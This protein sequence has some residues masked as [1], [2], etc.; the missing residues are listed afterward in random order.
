M[1][2][3]TSRKICGSATYI[4]LAKIPAFLRLTPKQADK[5]I[6]TKVG[7]IRDYFRRCGFKKAV[8]GLSGGIDSAVAA[9]LTA[10]AIGPENVIVLRLPCGPESVSVGIAGEICECLG[11]TA[12]NV[13]TVNINEAV[14]ESWRAARN[15]LGEVGDLKVQRG[16]MA[17]R[18]RMKILEHACSM[19][20]GILVGTENRTEHLLAY[21]TIGGDNISGLEPFLNLYK[22]QVY[23]LAARLGLPDSVLQR[24]PTAELWAGQTDEGELGVD[25]L[26]IDTILAGV[27]DWKFTP[28]VLKKLHGIPVETTRKVV[29]HVDSKTGKRESPYIVP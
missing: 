5:L 20:G 29:A 24:K 21:Y 14:N 11:V 2:A 1:K 4:D 13:F 3:K 16:N 9:A 12:A 17:A 18:E 23:T 19:F 28:F 25:Y 15:V 22:V 10:R 26:T 6:A 8:I 27:F 7:L